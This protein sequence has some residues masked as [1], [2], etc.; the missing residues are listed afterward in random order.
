[1]SQ[2]GKRF[3]KIVVKRYKTPFRSQLNFSYFP[4]EFDHYPA[5]MI[6]LKFGGTSMGDEHTW[7]TVLDIISTY[8]HPVVVVSATARTTRQLIAAGHAARDDLDNARLISHS[9]A[10]RHRQLI[11]NFLDD[12]HHPN[13][14]KIAATCHQW[15][16]DRVEF[17][18]VLLQHISDEKNLSLQIKDALAS[19]G[20]QLSAYLFAQCGQAYG[21]E[22]QW[23]DARK[24]IKTDS[25][26]GQANPLTQKISRQAKQLMKL[27]RDNIL[28]VMGGFYGENEEGNITTLGFEGSDYTASLVGAATRAEA[29]EI[30]TDVSGIYTCDPHVVSHA[31]PIPELSFQEATELAYFG[32][33][34]L[35]P[36]T[37]KPVASAHIPVYVKNIFDPD[38]PGTKI[39]HKKNEQRWAKAITYLQDIVILTVTSAGEHSGHAFL[40]R[41]FDELHRLHIPVSAVTTTEAAVSV[42]LQAE[43]VDDRLSQRFGDAGSVTL[44]PDQSLISIVGCSFEGARAIRETMFN[45]LQDNEPSLIS[46]S[47]AKQNFN[48]ALPKTELI[49]AVCRI[50]NILFP[51]EDQ[52]R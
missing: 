47:K 16:T 25:D 41:F 10:Q 6:V 19:I 28:P 11:T 49:P 46:Y 13:R 37:M 34:V 20:E 27:S 43:Y 1:M 50:H 7:R 9:I 24:V 52:L 3:L 44:Q 42:A 15:I 23:V 33:K 32:A 48:I 40:A 5:F 38:H 17:M 8:Q 22:T 18:D 12:A 29:I 21:L 4:P 31:R 30:W 14:D 2:K 45:A 39:H 26:F 35:H 36:A 51:P